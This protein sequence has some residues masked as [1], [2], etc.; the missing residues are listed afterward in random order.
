VN[1]FNLPTLTNEK[2][3]QL[4]DWLECE[5]ARMEKEKQ[6]Y[7]KVNMLALNY[8][9]VKKNNFFYV[10]FRVLSESLKFIERKYSPFTIRENKVFK[11]NYKVGTCV[12]CESITDFTLIFEEDP[13]LDPTKEYIMQTIPPVEIVNRQIKILKDMRLGYNQTLKS[14][15]FGTYQPVPYRDIAEIINLDFNPSQREATKNSLGT[16]DF[17]LILGPPGTGK[18]TIISELCEKLEARGKKVLL[19][20]WMNVAIDNAL[21]AVLKGGKVDKN[22]ICRLGAGDFKVAEDLLPLTFTGKLIRSELFDKRVV[23]STLASAYKAVTESNDLFDVVIVDE[24]GAATLPQTLLALVLGKKFILIG[25]HRQL[26]PVVSDENCPEWIRE[27]LFE[28]LWKMYPQ[29]HSMLHEQYRMDPAI[30]DIV[31][32]TVYH[33]LGGIKTPEFIGRRSSPFEEDKITAVKSLPAKKVINRIPICWADSGGTIQWINFD[34]SHSAKN[35]RETENIS[36]LLEILIEDSG[37]DPKTIGVLSPFRYQVSTMVKGLESFIEKGV[38]VNT[39]HSFQG[40]EK[41]IIIISMVVRNTKDSKIF[42]D[43]RLLNVAIT[44]TKFKLI[45]VSD[46]SISEGKDKASIIMSMLYDSSRKNG[47]YVAKD[48]LNPVQNEEIRKDTV[49]E[50]TIADT[51]QYLVKERKKLGFFGKR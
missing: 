42:E 49:K 8:K 25:D 19:T 1:I 5:K 31:S 46:T 3:L 4:I 20:S 47:G 23:G 41:D 10:D 45:I 6:T 34:S 21:L 27:S 48:A 11:V 28:K 39:I 35:D 14:I 36:K 29:K 24:A 30:A 37:I 51:K 38:A 15:L 18:T 12:K 33:D 40:N 7:I 44:R 32:R 26:P 22:L 2:I 17:H 16:Q 13:E 43:I 50:L 9:R